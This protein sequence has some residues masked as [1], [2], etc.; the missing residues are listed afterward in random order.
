MFLLSDIIQQ[1]VR[2]ENN[3]LFYYILNSISE[4]TGDLETVELTVNICYTSSKDLDLIIQLII[5]LQVLI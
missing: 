2:S 5:Y 1:L 3:S 4:F